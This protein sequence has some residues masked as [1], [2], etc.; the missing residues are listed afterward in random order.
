[1]RPGCAFENFDETLA[2]YPFF[3]ADPAAHNDFIAAKHTAD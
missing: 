3:I 2:N 1:M